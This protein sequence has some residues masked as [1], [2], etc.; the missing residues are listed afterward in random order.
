MLTEP[1]DLSI[2]GHSKS[3]SIE[4]EGRG[5]VIEKQTKTNRGRESPSTCVSSLFQKK[6]HAEIFK[7]KFYIYSPVFPIDY[8]GR[9]KY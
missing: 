9:M 3:K 2:R 4:E 1:V 6:K 7:M 8:H 5:K